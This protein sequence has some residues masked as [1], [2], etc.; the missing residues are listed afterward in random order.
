[1]QLIQY[2]IRMSIVPNYGVYVSLGTY[3]Q[4]RNYEYR[5]TMS[6]LSELGLD[7][8]GSILILYTCLSINQFCMRLNWL[9]QLCHQNIEY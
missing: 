9:G 1:M 4:V 7:W 6:K 8:A 5:T 3:A 2:V